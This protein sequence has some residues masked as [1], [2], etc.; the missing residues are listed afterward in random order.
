M[1]IGAGGTIEV[2]SATHDLGTG[3]YTILAQLA[4]D[5]FG[6]EPHQVVVRIGDRGCRTRRSPAV[7]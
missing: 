4:A 2:V 6:V 5:A 3:M 1:T 7:R